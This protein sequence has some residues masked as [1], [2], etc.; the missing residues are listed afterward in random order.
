[1]QKYCETCRRLVDLQVVSKNSLGIKLVCDCGT[2]YY[3]GKR[4]R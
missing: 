3:Q 1:M 4:R 2:L